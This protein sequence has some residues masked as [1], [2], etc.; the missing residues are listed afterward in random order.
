MTISVKQPGSYISKQVFHIPQ[1]VD[2]DNFKT[3]WERTVQLCSNLRTRIILHQNS[4]IQMI[5]KYDRGDVWDE[6]NGLDRRSFL[7][8]SHTI[9]MG[10]GSRLYR[11]ALVQ[12]P[13][14]QNFFCL[15]M[16]HAIFDGWTMSIM[17]RTLVS[18]YQQ[19]QALTVYPY[20]RFVKYTQD[21]DQNE[22]TR[23]WQDQLQDAQKASFPDPAENLNVQKQ[24]KVFQKHLEISWPKDTSVTKASV[25]RAA[26]AVVLSR[27]CTSDDI[28][29]GAVVSGRN[30]SV[31]G[32]EGVTGLITAT[33]P[34]RVR[35]SRDEPVSHFV[36][37]IQTQASDMV[38]HEQFGIQNIA[39]LGPDAKAACDFSSL[40]IVQPG[41]HVEKSTSINPEAVLEPDESQECAIQ[42]SMQNFL[43]YPLVVQ[44]VLQGSQTELFIMYDPNA[45]TE[46]QSIAI[47]H[48]IEHVI[49][50]MLE[51]GDMLLGELSVSGPWDLQQAI[52]FN[53][54][55]DHNV[56][57]ACIHDLVSNHACHEPTREAIYSTESFI[58]LFLGVRPEIMVPFCFE[59]SPWAIIAMLGIMKAGGAF[60]PLDP[61]HPFDRRKSLVQEV[62]A[63]IVLVSPS[64]AQAC[65]GIA[66]LVIEISEQFLSHLKV[67]DIS[68]QPPKT[69]SSPDNA[70]YTLFTSGSTG[71]P[72]GVLITHSAI[73]TSL[74]GQRISMGSSSSSRWFQ[75]ANYIF[76]ACIS[77]IWGPLIQGGVVCVPTDRERLHDAANFI[78]SSQSNIG[79]LTPS[80]VKTLSPLAVPSLKTLNLGGE[81]PTKDLLD[82]WFEHVDLRN[83]YG[84]TEACISCAYYQYKSPNESPTI[85]GNGFVHNTWIVDPENHNHLAP[86]GCIGELLVQGWSLARGYIGDGEK[87][88]ASFVNDVDWIPHA[89]P[90]HEFGSYKTGDLAKYNPDGTIS[91]LGR[92]DAQVK[93]RGQRIEIGEIEYQ[94]SAADRF[95]KQVAVELI[96]SRSHD[97]LVALFTVDDESHENDDVQTIQ[98]TGKTQLISDTLINLYSKL[99]SQLPEYMIP[100]Y[101]IPVARI[102]QNSAGKLDRKSLATFLAAMSTE[103]LS[104]WSLSQSLP[105]RECRTDIQ[106]WLR[107]QWAM[108]L[109]MPATT[110]SVDDNFYNLGGDSIRIVTLNKLISEKFNV[111][112]GI[113]LL[114]SKQT[115]IGIMATYIEDAR[116][117]RLAN[118]TSLSVADEI[119]TVTNASWARHP[120]RSIENPI[121][122][123]P[124]DATIFLTGATG[125]L[126][127]EILR[128]LVHSDAIKTV[129]VLV[130][131]KSSRMGL[132]R[133]K[134]AARITGW[135]RDNDKD[136]IEVWTGDLSQPHLGL[137]ESQWSQLTKS[138]D[139]QVDA[140]IHNGAVVNW[141]ADYTKLKAANVDSTVDLLHLASVSAS[142][143]KFVFV[144]GGIQVSHDDEVDVHAPIINSLNG[145]IQTKFVAERVVYSM[146]QKLPSQQNRISIVMPGRIIG[147]ASTGVANVDDFLWR[148]VSCAAAMRKHP[149]DTQGLWMQIADVSTVA[150]GIIGQVFTQGEVSSYVSA[151]GLIPESLFW[152]QVNA[153][154][155]VQCQP[156]SWEEW[157][158]SA[159]ESM[160]QAGEKHPLWPVQHFVSRLG[161]P[162]EKE[163]IDAEDYTELCRAVR[164]NVRYLMRIGFIQASAGEFG[165]IREA[166]MKRMHTT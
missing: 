114:N 146:S 12:E 162:V 33:V 50:Q 63:R 145:Y 58:S 134:D 60:V 131:S 120:Q 130:R 40:M 142:N 44:F 55:V 8:N 140:F 92:K 88:K 6:V 97:T 132:E 163:E 83:A 56:V 98:V 125:Y 159:M 110:I 42:D 99:A 68:L 102:P 78:T 118:K 31:S 13:N 1:H 73:C 21:L 64:T 165:D 66:E 37:G 158:T 59:K 38:A 14:G 62:N 93:I 122:S 10:Y 79:V 70:A 138:G 74:M 147:G 106:R 136:K 32:I 67:L 15:L 2:L 29:F 9:Q 137:E 89:V 166:T 71:K 100:Q 20:N 156:V 164:S 49:S 57:Q 129:I 109:A 139:G 39:K 3:A 75:F 108:V 81:A 124:A 43:N 116:E 48:Q 69:I 26:W 91:Y 123:L 117:E 150:E 104:R 53:S 45:V 54:H 41:Q 7:R 30:A 119:T 52:K 61:G 23:F 113:S 141:N 105:F 111:Q 133:V 16:H 65:E 143:P 160:N 107:D 157:Q 47:S 82:T 153:E 22:A 151:T 34:V 154:L 27:Y 112:L 127:T 25:L 121:T 90:G 85:I 5:V 144:T 103:D 80:F 149:S 24:T 19:S 77:E 152:D 96:Q 84:P 115:T 18:F 161:K 36:R 17:L 135:W 128:Q 86:I 155:K 72:K 4:S 46:Q 51:S 126:G 87:T 148:M 35:L 28:C 94:I 95:I 101:L 11:A 76:D